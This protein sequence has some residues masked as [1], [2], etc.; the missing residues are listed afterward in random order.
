MTLSQM[1]NGLKF[2]ILLDLGNDTF[3]FR[4]YTDERDEIISFINTSQRGIMKKYS[5]NGRE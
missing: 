4:V 3:R 1:Y 5:R 2:L